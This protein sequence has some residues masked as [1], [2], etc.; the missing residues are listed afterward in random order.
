MDPKNSRSELTMTFRVGPAFLAVACFIAACGG[1]RVIKEPE[2]LVLTESLAYASDTHVSANLDW[3]IY[4]DGPGAWAEKVDWD[5]YLIR[6]QNISDEPIR[7]IDVVVFDSIG[8]RIERGGNRR[9][10]VEGTKQ[11]KRRYKDEGLKVEEGPGAFVIASA[12]VA[13]VTGVAL[14]AASAVYVG[15]TGGV[16]LGAAATSLIFLPVLAVDGVNRAMKHQEVDEQIRSR[17]TLFPAELQP[18]QEQQL[19]LFFSLAPSPKKVELTYIDSDGA[20]VL[21]IDT[22][23]ALAGLHLAQANRKQ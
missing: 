3:V 13:G 22:S 6:L 12:A 7:V 11:T 15:A 5:E 1:S 20:H 17:Q 18:A 23:S 16:A 8:T 10:L 14:G 21:A 2:P 19:D 9:Q 4:R